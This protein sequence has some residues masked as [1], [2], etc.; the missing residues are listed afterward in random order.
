H[1]LKL[2]E[3]EGDAAFVTFDAL[4]VNASAQSLLRLAPVIE[5]VRL[6]KPYL[7]LRRNDANRYNVDDI[8]ALLGSQPPSK[9][10]SRFSVNNIQL[11]NGRVEFED[12]PAKTSNAITDITLG[13]PFVSSLAA[14]VKIFVEPLLSAKVN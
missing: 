3:P 4:A 1:D 11:E 12:R 8:I 13:V 14:D 5:E 9:E 10:P 2:M 7:H 6:T